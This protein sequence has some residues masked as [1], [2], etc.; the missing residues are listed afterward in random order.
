LLVTTGVGYS[1]R[2]HEDP[3]TPVRGA[4]GLSRYAV[5]ESIIPARG[6]VSEYGA[7]SS[8]KQSWDVFDNHKPRLKFANNSRVLRPK[9]APSTREASAS[10]GEADVLARESSADDID[11]SKIV[12]S[13]G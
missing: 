11:F 8:T 2:D 6:Q 10:A 7:E 1:P 12:S 4:E 5:P 9:A 3:V 13:Y